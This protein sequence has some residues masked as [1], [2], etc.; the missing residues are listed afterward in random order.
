MIRLDKDSVLRHTGLCGR[1]RQCRAV[2]E[3]PL[4][5]T[6][7]PICPIG[8]S[9]KFEAY[10]A[11]G[12]ITTAAKY[13]KG[14]IGLEPSLVKLAY[15]CALCGGCQ[16]QCPIMNLDTM[17]TTRFLR[18]EAVDKGLADAFYS[19]PDTTPLP[20][21][22]AMAGDTDTGLF[23]GC[24][25]QS[26]VKYAETVAALLKS[27]GVRFQPVTGLCCGAYLKRKGDVDGFERQTAENRKAL[28]R[29]GIHR[30]LAIDPLCCETLRGEYDGVEVLHF[31][32][33]LPQTLPF[34]TDKPRKVAYH[35]PCRL[36]RGCGV[37]D[38]PR[39]ILRAAGAELVE[40]KR[41]RENSLCCGGRPD[42][43]K[44][45]GLEASAARMRE[46]AEV[47]AECVVT[48]C[49]SCVK[50]LR[51]GACAAGVDIPVFDLAEYIKIK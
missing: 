36:G 5:R 8:E 44:E 13:L 49:S 11:S 17:E 26:D 45:A 33:A 46:A 24:Q 41:A 40:F 47:Q 6:L 20:F 18:Q 35:D 21:E 37:Y 4:A 10:F 9:R 34:T 19:M 14:E 48:A 25:A 2:C 29:Q 39:D 31:S 51:L 23:I 22:T 30:L 12:R 43:D 50:Q 16:P 42:F 32:E 28:A 1:C 27:A 38:V 7:L 3:R 15:S